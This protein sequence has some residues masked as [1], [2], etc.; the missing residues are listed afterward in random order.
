[1]Q[2][3]LLALAIAAELFATLCLRASA[4]L[5]RPWPTAGAA[6]GYAVAFW[7]LSAVLVRGMPVG[8]A[9]AIWSACGV[10]AVALLAWWLFGET[11]TWMQGGGLLLIIVGVVAL[12]LGG[13]H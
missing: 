12:E 3:L 4:G 2:Y 9:Y 7:L 8:V 11:L 5:S 1:M 10:A 6:V 13:A